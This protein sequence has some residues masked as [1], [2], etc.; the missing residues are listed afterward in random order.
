ME[1]VETATNWPTSSVTRLTLGGK[2]RS[3]AAFKVSSSLHQTK[4]AV[5]TLVPRTS[6]FC[7]RLVFAPFP[8]RQD[9]KKSAVR[10][11]AARSAPVH[12]FLAMV[13]VWA[14][15]TMPI[16]A[17]A[18]TASRHIR[19]LA[20]VRSTAPLAAPVPLAAMVIHFEQ[21][22]LLFHFP[23]TYL[24]SDLPPNNCVTT[25]G[26]IVDLWENEGPASAKARSASPQ[27]Q[28]QQQNLSEPWP[29]DGGGAVAP[30]AG[31]K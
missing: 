4:L 21:F 13:R 16:L 9:R 30:A 19:I 2:P 11:S 25:T 6:R 15:L 26:L 27:P 14:G 7:P 1:L 24:P 8:A 12:L 29:A 5:T 10:L 18:S 31:C 20:L 22:N 23:C 17:R 3:R 28:C